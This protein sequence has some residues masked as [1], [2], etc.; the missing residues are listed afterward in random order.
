MVFISVQFSKQRFISSEF[1]KQGDGV[2]FRCLHP[3]KT[4][5]LHSDMDWGRSI[6]VPAHWSF[7]FWTWQPAK[8]R[9]GVTFY[10]GA[11]F[12]LV[13][14][15]CRNLDACL[16]WLHIW[17]ELRFKLA[18]YGIRTFLYVFS[19]SGVWTGFTQTGE[20]VR[21]LNWFSHPYR[22]SRSTIPA[23]LTDR[24]FL[25]SIDRPIL[26]LSICWYNPL[27]LPFLSGQFNSLVSFARPVHS[28]SE[29]AKLFWFKCVTH[30]ASTRWHE[31]LEGTLWER[32]DP[33]IWLWIYTFI[34]SNS[35]K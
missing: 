9:T 16:F 27:L 20:I 1:F 19:E 7:Y 17:S 22:G 33:S 4:H 21:L 18:H 15:G 11:Y 14:H 24:L 25:F 26:Y 31:P 5:L 6:H 30:V 28:T 23:Y 13:L 32:I 12:W 34:V 10:F 29:F 2:C 35:S 3:T 8:P